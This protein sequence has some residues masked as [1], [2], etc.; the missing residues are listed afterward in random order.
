MGSIEG[1]SEFN[2]SVTPAVIVQRKSRQRVA[3][4]S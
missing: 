4:E 1:R 3:P 2:Y